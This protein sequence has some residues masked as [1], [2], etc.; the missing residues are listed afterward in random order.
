M[1]YCCLSI[2][3]ECWFFLSSRRRH[4]ICAL[5]TGVQTCALPI[6]PISSGLQSP[7]TD[8]AGGHGPAIATSGRRDAFHRASGDFRALH[9]SADRRIAARSEERRVGEG[10]V[11]TCRS[12][13]SPYQSKKKTDTKN[14]CNM[15][16][17]KDVCRMND[18]Y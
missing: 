13:G 6:F 8:P 5:V 9:C 11:S 18:R 7:E 1:V 15:T 14:W 10:G 12:R 16:S 3:L 17:K 4:T 2:C